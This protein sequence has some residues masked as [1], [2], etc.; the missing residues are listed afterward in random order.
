MVHCLC[1]EQVSQYFILFG[2][3]ELT[4][5]IE[6]YLQSDMDITM[7]D[8]TVVTPKPRKN[9][10]EEPE[11]K[12][13][14][15]QDKS[16]DSDY[17][18]PR[19]LKKNRKPPIILSSDDPDFVEKTDKFDR[20]MTSETESNGQNN[21]SVYENKASEGESDRKRESENKTDSQG[22]RKVNLT[23]AHGKAKK[24]KKAFRKEVEEKRAVATRMNN[25]KVTIVIV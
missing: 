1:I 6:T 21:E 10:V 16:E 20:E 25:K 14:D 15:S 3:K 24:D 5:T 2:R 8:I 4:L 23:K 18:T 13:E 12:S 7:Q 11:S 19:V 17:E 22:F 9:V